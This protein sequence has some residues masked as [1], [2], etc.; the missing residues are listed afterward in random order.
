MK[1]DSNYKPPILGGTEAPARRS[2]AANPGNS[3]EVTL[4]DTA[5]HLAA[6]DDS[7]FVDSARIQE[8]KAAISQ[9]RFQ[10][11]AGA[12]ADRLIVSARELIDS[13]RRG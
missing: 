7:E 5:A 9:G 8:I 4:S 12:I 3:A 6:S 10:I 2:I 13:Q 11:N 1:I